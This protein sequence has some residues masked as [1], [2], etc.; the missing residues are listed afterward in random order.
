MNCKS[1]AKS[2]GSGPAVSIRIIACNCNNSSALYDLFPEDALEEYSISSEFA[3]T[4][5]QFLDS[6]GVLVEFEA[7]KPLVVEV[8]PLLNVELLNI[9]NLELLGHRIFAVIQLFQETWRDGKVVASSKLGYLT[10]IAE[11]STHDNGVVA[12]LLVVIEDLLDRFDTW[13]VLRVV[14]LLCVGL[15]PIE[16]ATDERRN[17]IG[18][19]LSGCDGLDDGEHE[20]EVAVHA[21]SAL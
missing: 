21:V 6:H 5:R 1:K 14:L 16:N 13:V 15:V 4:L 19:G 17:E 3:D 2:P 7:E 12:V 11:R 20:C 18:T 8:C 10:K 9:I